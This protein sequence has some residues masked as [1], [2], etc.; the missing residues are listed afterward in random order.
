MSIFKRKLHIFKKL[1]QNRQKRKS[2]QTRADEGI[3]LYES[4]RAVSYVS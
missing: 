1:P 3:R 2:T 4:I